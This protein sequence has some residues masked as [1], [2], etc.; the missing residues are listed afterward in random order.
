VITPTPRSSVRF[1]L[2]EDNL[3]DVMLFRYALDAI[4]EPYDLQV[5]QDG[6]EALAYIHKHWTRPPSEEPCLIILD[7]RLPKVDGIA[8]LEKLRQSPGLAHVKTAVVTT[9]ASPA[10]EAKLALLKV[11]LYRNKPSNIDEF[12]QLGRE[13]FEICQGEPTNVA[14]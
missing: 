7:L 6:A 3:G 8:I 2:I 4:G 14:A 13:I 10:E 11:D 1:V 12:L 9:G 5:L